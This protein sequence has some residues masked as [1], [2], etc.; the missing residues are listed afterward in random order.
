MIHKVIV[1][2]RF[3]VAIVAHNVG[4]PVL[5]LF[6]QGFRGKVGVDLSPMGTHIDNAFPAYAARRESVGLLEQRLETAHVDVMAAR[7]GRDG[8]PG[9]EQVFVAHKAI[10]IR[11]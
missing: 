3:G 7:E 4:F 11:G 2:L 9:R 5:E 10:V 6:R 8:F 1:G